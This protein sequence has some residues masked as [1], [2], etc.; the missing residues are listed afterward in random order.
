MKIYKGKILLVL[1]VS[2]LSHVEGTSSW[3]EQ[4]L[5]GWYYFEDPKNEVEI[6]KKD[7][8]P[9]LAEQMIELKKVELKK[10]LSLALLDPTE[11]HVETYIAE[12]KKWVDQSSAFAMTWGKV[13]LNNPAL[14]ETVA[15]PTSNYGILL[16]REH[17]LQKRRHLLKALSKEWFLVCFFNGHEFSSEK[18]IEVMDLF[19]TINGWKTR[20]ISLDGKGVNGLESFEIDKG[21]SLHF[22]VKASPSFFMVHPLA[23][24]A[25]PVGAGL[26]S[27]TEIEEHIES[28]IGEVD[29]EPKFK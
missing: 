16:K 2:F 7:L 27:M 10:L 14:N 20:A 15:N 17:D 28:Q 13:L 4:K 8:T 3:Y 19:G 25:I 23:N 29:D 26:I 9:D 5:E 22:G 21:I 1:I 12:Q 6:K 24:R 11:R 18:A